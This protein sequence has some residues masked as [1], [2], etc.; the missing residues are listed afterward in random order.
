MLRLEMDL[1][2]PSDLVRLIDELDRQIKALLD[3][4]EAMRNANIALRYGRDDALRNLDFSDVHILALK[5]RVQAGLDGFP[6]YVFRNNRI[7]IRKLQDERSELKVRFQEGVAIPTVVT[8]VAPKD[9]NTVSY[10][11]NQ[12]WIGSGCTIY[13]I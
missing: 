2:A 9:P 5:E 12:T 3:A 7:V 11:M 6:E 1:K 8:G 4:Q 10:N 13:P